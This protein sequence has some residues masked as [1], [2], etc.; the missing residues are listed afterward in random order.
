[1]TDARNS[2]GF[3]NKNPG[4]IDFNPKNKWK[5]QVGLGDVWLPQP[6]RR[7]AEFEDHK[8]GIRALAALL[9]TYQD[10][11]GLRT[12]R[13]IINRWAPPNENSTSSYV[14]FVDEQMPRHSSSDFV[15]LHKWEDMRELVEAIIRH[16]LGGMPY[17]KAQIDEGLRL[18]GLV[19]DDKIEAAAV[20]ARRPATVAA[21]G[22]GLTVGGI[23]VVAVVEMVRQVAPVLEDLDST[24]LIA[25]VGAVVIVGVALL[26]RRMMA[27]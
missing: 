27:K 26:L 22:T 20:E 21:A 11:Y 13:Q 15:D 7:F 10:R 2:R 19:P 9:T 14:N 8:W 6:Q 24:T 12:I 4:N 16:E 3:R 1:M 23:S 5:G 18:A 17:T 25:A